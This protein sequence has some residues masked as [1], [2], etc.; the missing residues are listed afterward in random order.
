MSQLTVVKNIRLSLSLIKAN[1]FSAMEY[2]ASFLVQV[3]G[4]FI[5]DIGLLLCWVILYQRFP[6]INSWSLYDTYII[7]AINTM[8]FGLLEIF[9]GGSSRIAGIIARGELDYFLAIPKNV[10]WHV[11]VSKTEISAIGDLFFG[12]AVFIFLVHPGLMQFVILGVA[13]F[14]SVVVLLSFIIIVNSMAFFLDNFEDASEN[15]VHA[16]LMMVLY[17]DPAYRGFLK[18]IAMVA[19]PSI[20]VSVFPVELVRNFN[21]GHLSVLAGFSILIFSAALFIFNQGLKRY[22]SG[23]LINVRL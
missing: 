4:M 16:M 17:P 12:L 9:A 3:F 7:F 5:N 18:I 21:W 1:I 2:R 10:L 23:N 14:F 15:F 20:F 6:E 8:N 11:L 19:I 22:E 13:L